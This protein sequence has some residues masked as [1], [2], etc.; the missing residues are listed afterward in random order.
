VAGVSLVSRSKS[1]GQT[2]A[3][4]SVFP[5]LAPRNLL[6]RAAAK[7]GATGALRLQGRDL[8]R[9]ALGVPS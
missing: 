8:P 1:A 6:Q 7:G 4:S 9:P 3:D 2:A 5:R